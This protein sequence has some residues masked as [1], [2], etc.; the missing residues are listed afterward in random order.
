MNLTKIISV[1][2][3]IIAD[4]RFPKTI[5]NFINKTYIK[6]FK[7]NMENFLPYYY[8]KSLN[9]LFTRGLKKNID[10]DK[11]ADIFISP[12]DGYIMQSGNSV[13]GRAL[14]IKGFSYSIEKLLGERVE[15]NLFYINIYLSPS[16]YHRYHSPCDMYVESITHFKGSLLPVN[17][18]SLTKNHN[19][20]IRNERVIL[21]AKDIFNKT[22][23]FVAIGAL[24]VGNIVFYIEPRLQDKFKGYKNTFYYNKPK[25][26]KKG[27]ELGMFKM[28][29]TIVFFSEEKLEILKTDCKISFGESLFRRIRDE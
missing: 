25:F 29:S 27:E 9:E 15:S 3:G 6:I 28:G 13:N 17:L 12:S 8:Y 4:I 16:N 11:N 19:L 23:Y 10:F 7:I 14:Q 2:F 18:K 1:Y 26:V 5:Q 21:K 20:F 24:N 22:L